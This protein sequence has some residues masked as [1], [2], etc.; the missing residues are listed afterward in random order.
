[1]HSGKRAMRT[2]VWA[3]TLNPTLLPPSLFIQVTNALRSFVEVRAASG[4]TCAALI[5]NYRI[6]E[7]MA[8]KMRENAVTTVTFDLDEPTN[9]TVEWVNRMIGALLTELR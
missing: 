3:V 2:P 4:T 8:A 5:T 6:T 9:L 1:M 7:A